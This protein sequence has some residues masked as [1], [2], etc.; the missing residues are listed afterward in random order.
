MAATDRTGHTMNTYLL[1]ATAAASLCLFACPAGFA[2]EAESKPFRLQSALGAELATRIP[3]MAVANWIV[4]RMSHRRSPRPKLAVGPNELGAQVCRGRTSTI[5]ALPG[6][7]GIPARVDSRHCS[8]PSAVDALRR[9]TPHAT[10]DASIR[11]MKHH[12]SHSGFWCWRETW[13]APPPGASE[14]MHSSSKTNPSL[15]WR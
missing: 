14:C 2:Q 9:K 12:Q 8:H 3:G 10:I 11:L 15:P 1:R 7:S 6:A 4:C 13:H 5:A